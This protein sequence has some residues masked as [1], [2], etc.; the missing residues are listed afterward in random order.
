MTEEKNSALTELRSA[1]EA[2]N[3][4]SSKE[5]VAGL[6]EIRSRIEGIDAEIE[7][8]K[9]TDTLLGANQVKA[10][11]S[12]EN[13]SVQMDQKK[14]DEIE[15]RTAENIFRN[16]EVRES[17]D[18]YREA[19]LE[20]RDETGASATAIDPNITLG[21]ATPATPGDGGITVPHA[22]YN[23]VIKKL[24][25]TSP[26]FNMVQ[27]VNSITGTI[28]FPRE[29]DVSEAGWIG[30]AENAGSISPNLDSVELTQKRVGISIQ[31]TQQIINDSA[32]G[33]VDYA[34]YR[35]SRGLAKTLERGI[36]TGAKK[37]TDA[38]KSFRGVV[39]ANTT[40]LQRTFAGEGPT[41]EEL[42]DTYTS[43]NPGYLDGSL[44][45]VSR[46]VFNVMAK[47][48]DGDGQYLILRGQ[49][50][51]RPG[52]T[53]F[54]APITVSDTLN[55]Q[56]TQLIFGNFE[57]GYKLMVKQG[58]K[59]THVTA[60]TKQTLSGGHLIVLDGYMDGAVTNPD[61]FVTAKVTPKA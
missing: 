8:V 50:N 14:F 27:K 43:L 28:S 61:A 7:E 53:L 55:D 21:N 58:L 4:E 33:I 46:P 49:V 42:I 17:L 34:T 29:T 37:G 6:K 47:L 35:L 44:W 13:R 25:E 18:K 9:A 3:E 52:Y 38:S 10:K 23:Q 22:V 15:K 24:D 16:V 39:G 1:R 31:L 45:V 40:E 30:E 60:D 20:L 54:G 5:D 41:V 19:V 26:I 32:V 57:A 56:T 36:L 11:D 2:I 59:L 12:T 48:K 51:G